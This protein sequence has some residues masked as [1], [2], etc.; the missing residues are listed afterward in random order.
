MPKKPD[1][2]RMVAR[3]RA[4]I[5]AAIID[6]TEQRSYDYDPYY[7]CFNVKCY[8]VDMSLPN[9]LAKWREYEGDPAHT[10]NPEWLKNVKERYDETSEETLC[11][12]GFE[13]ARAHFVGHGDGFKSDTFRTLYDGT[14]V[15]VEYGF[16][17]RSG[18][19]LAIT[20]FEGVK[21]NQR[22]DA[23]LETELMDMDF[24]T[25]KRLYQLVLML[26]HDTRRSAIKSEVEMQAAFNFFANAC[27]DIHEPNSVQ[28]ELFETASESE[29]L[30]GKQSV[31]ERLAYLRGEI[32][33]EC[34][35]YEEIAELQQ[36]GEQ[37][38]IPEDDVVLR[39]WA[40]L[41]E[42]V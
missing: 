22:L 29:I 9:L 42:H 1:A 21:Y 11:D 4:D 23:G 16:V 20:K 25:L 27:A 5:V 30:T 13:D 32:E 39:E 31:S 37:N 41:P 14:E 26:K 34:I 10:H 40:G 8:D 33:A 2:Y 24:P 19:W 6:L 15:D 35:S 36:L 28:G 17:G 3:S 18:G 38:Q 12:W 7:F